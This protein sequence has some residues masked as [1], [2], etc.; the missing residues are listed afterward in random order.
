M[1]S[2]K[3]VS[4]DLRADFGFFKKPDYN[5]GLLLSYN[6]LHK[7]ALLGVLGAI[8][9]L[10]GYEKKGEMPEYYQKLKDLPIGIE[11][12]GN[13]KG[14]FQRTSVKYTNTVGYA[15]QDGNLLIEESILIKP[16]YRCYLLLNIQEREHQ[17]LYEYLQD[18]NAEYIPYLG[19]NEFQASW[20]DK[21]G[22][23]SFR[24]Y[25][26]E[27]VNRTSAGKEFA[28]SF[29]KSFIVKDNLNEPVEEEYNP[30]ELKPGPE[31]F[32]YFERI[33]TSFDNVLSQYKIEPVAYSNL[34][35]AEGITL[36]GL[37]YLRDL[38]K[39]VQLL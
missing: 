1:D 32:M 18:G 36:P 11:P 30:F 35:T 12:L 21:E 7:P 3:L 19:K 38:D 25:E 23:N 8:I 9:G 37:F 34:L 17:K 22:E 26:F 5:D 6:L 33:P 16:A 4:F 2:Q 14:N 31:T 29:R 13:E 15:N 27:R 20:I 28:G 10:K 39:Y 24:Q